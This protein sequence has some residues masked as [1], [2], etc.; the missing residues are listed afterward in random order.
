[1]SQSPD[2]LPT[3]APPGDWRLFSAEIRVS[4]AYVEALVA[5]GVLTA[6]ERD[7]VI[8]ALEQIKREFEGGTFKPA[9]DDLF[10]A[11]DERLLQIAPIE[12]AKLN[13]ARSRSEQ[14]V[15][16][17]RLWVMDELDGLI[18][19]LADIQRAL[20]QQAETHLG[21]LMP[22]YTHMQPAGVVTVCHWLLSYFWM[23][24]RDQER[25][26]SMI[27]R[28]SQCPMGS[29]AIGGIPYTLDRSSLAGVIGFADI[30]Q[31]SMDA[32]GDLDFGAELLFYASLIGVHLSRLAEDFILYSN[33]A[34]GF[35]RVDDAYTVRS[36]AL[37]AKRNPNAVERA[38][39]KA[40]LI[41][42]DLAGFLATLKGLPSTY[43][44]DTQEN[45][46]ALYHALDTLKSMMLV[47][48]GVISTLQFF[49]ER[50]L[51]ALD[52]RVLMGDLADYLI[53]RGVSHREAFGVVEK[54]IIR[55]QRAEK[56]LAELPL[57]EFQAESKAFD[58]DV[59]AIFD[60][61]RA[62]AQR[63][64]TGGTAPAAQRKQI[65]AALDWMVENGL[66]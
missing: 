51:K 25:L 65:R 42:G 45:R 5:P 10:G 2:A 63:N 53:S 29:G 13:A 8:S 52:E 35:V 15:T 41:L 33:P 57:G 6:T 20:I 21:T 54:L 34:L 50:M 38:R 62:A 17:L 55:A 14:T 39:G 3:T 12:S 47:I 48:E 56:A 59:F 31:N 36:S 49:P 28:T 27:G 46:L 16:A 40:G 64:V 61:A 18:N 43:N 37:P 32:I 11:L 22:G 58:A 23:L 44:Q 26:V 1:M 9:D 30:T 7:A 19:A 24:A 4:L 60:F 66:E